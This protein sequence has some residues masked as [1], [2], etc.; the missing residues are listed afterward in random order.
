MH[1]NASPPR[2]EFCDVSS[3]TRRRGSGKLRL[4]CHE[5]QADV[6]GTSSCHISRHYTRERR[7][8]CSLP[9]RM[10][11]SD[12][13]VLGGAGWTCTWPWLLYNFFPTDGPLPSSRRLEALSKPICGW[14][15]SLSRCNKP[16][17]DCLVSPA[18]SGSPATRQ[19]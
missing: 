6:A 2:N 17:G 15:S 11:R 9:R 10:S 3:V 7:S 12:L 4:P 13:V 8:Y 1:H 5:V 14:I 19:R 18:L 16:I